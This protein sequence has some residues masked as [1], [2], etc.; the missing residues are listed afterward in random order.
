MLDGYYETRH[1]PT[2]NGYANEQLIDYKELFLQMFVGNT[3]M[4]RV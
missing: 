2:G 4:A 1:S 3:T